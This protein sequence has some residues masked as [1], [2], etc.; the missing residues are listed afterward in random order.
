MDIGSAIDFIVN[1]FK[2]L[3]NLLNSRLVFTIFGTQISMVNFVVTIMIVLIVISV[4]WKG[5]KV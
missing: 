3:Y 1:T 5:A 2:S 4:F